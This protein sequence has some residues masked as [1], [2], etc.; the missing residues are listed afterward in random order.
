MQAHDSID[1]TPSRTI[2][3]SLY[4]GRA[5][6]LQYPKDPVGHVSLPMDTA[7]WKRIVDTISA[8]MSVSSVG[9]SLRDIARAAAT[10]SRG[11]CGPVR[12][13]A[14]DGYV[15]LATR[16]SDGILLQTALHT[17]AEL[18][19]AVRLAAT[20]GTDHVHVGHDEATFTSAGHDPIVLPDPWY[21]LHLAPL[22]H[23]FLAAEVLELRNLVAPQTPTKA[24][25]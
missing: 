7:S 11:P 8:N 6:R 22:S 14:S 3:L 9:D 1:K 19:A 5:P 15:Q 23:D 2:T 18:D 10:G 4:L 16:R 24:I 17:I 20:L 13:R 12:V 25:P 21:H